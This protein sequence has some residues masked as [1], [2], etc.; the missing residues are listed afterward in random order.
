MASCEN[1][2][3]EVVI[4]GP[5]PGF[6]CNADIAKEEL[7]MAGIDCGGQE[8]C[9][10]A[11]ITIRNEGCDKIVIDALKC[12]NAD[13]CTDATFNFV[14]DIEVATCDL[15]PSGTSASGLDKCFE[16]LSQLP[17]RVRAPAQC[18]RW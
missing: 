16:N 15:G 14:G 17:I 18:V 9:R 8:S 2:S 7:I 10:G 13:S 12:F 1:M 4:P 3:F 6:E 5:P 11:Q